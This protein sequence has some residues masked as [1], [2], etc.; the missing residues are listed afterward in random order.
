VL[1]GSA[2]QGRLTQDSDVDLAVA[3][4]TPLSLD[5][6]LEIAAALSLA[7][8]REVD[9]VDLNAADGLLLCEALPGRLVFSKDVELYAALM[10]RMWYF[11]EDMLPLV[12]R[13]M[14]AR[15]RRLLHDD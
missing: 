15:V 11:R 10:R 8:D 12:H 7:L 5:R 1:Y 14:D 13:S 9:L 2:A 6:R 4:L 3:G